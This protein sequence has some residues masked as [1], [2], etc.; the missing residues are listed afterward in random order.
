MT[1]APYSRGLGNCARG[2]S[3]RDPVRTIEQAIAML[4][5]DG[6]HDDADKLRA[7]VRNQKE[8]A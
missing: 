7:W 3:H 1:P 5:A 6:K 2:L 4:D 8:A